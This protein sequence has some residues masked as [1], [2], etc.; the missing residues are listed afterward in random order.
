MHWFSADPHYV[1]DR[2]I[3]FC[4]RPLGF[5]NYVQGQRTQNRPNLFHD[6]NRKSP[7]SQ[8]G[9]LDGLPLAERPARPDRPAGEEVLP[10]LPVLRRSGPESGK[11]G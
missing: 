5:L 1:H 3:G 8:I 7:K 10:L 2:I 4:G 6:L 9:D 11:P